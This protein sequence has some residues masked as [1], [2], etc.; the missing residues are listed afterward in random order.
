MQNNIDSSLYPTTNGVG[1]FVRSMLS[2]QSAELVNNV[3]AIIAILMVVAL[4]PVVLIWLERKVAAHFQAR[5]GPMRVG[6]HGMLQPM[7]DGI[8]LIF[9]EV[10]KPEGADSFIFFLA[11]IL[12]ATA[13]FLVLTVIPFDHHLQVTDL[14]AGVLYVI[15]VSGLGVMGVLLAG[16][17]SNNKYSLLG[18]MRSGAQMISYEISLAFLMLLIVLLSGTASLREIVFSQQGTVMD[19]WIFKFPVFGFIAFV[20]FLISSTAELNRG[21]FDIAEAESELTGGFSTEYSGISFAMF[22]LAEF[23]NMF[24]AAALTTTFFLGGFLSPQFGIA[25]LDQVLNMVP[26]FIWFFLKSY[27]VIFIFMWFRWTFPRPRVDQLMDLEWKIL[28]PLNLLIM[29]TGGIFVGMGWV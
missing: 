4:S 22:F 13:S 6:W 9:K 27:V 18:A 8:K 25:P 1:D 19:W 10:L 12:P 20:L 14:P 11:P 23:V 17:S 7:A 26:G 21:P 2:A 24:V 15:A 28:L 29:I 5:L 16:W 3:L